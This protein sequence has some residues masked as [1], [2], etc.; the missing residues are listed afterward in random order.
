MTLSLRRVLRLSRWNVVLLS[1]N[2]L[3]LFYAV[4]LPLLP[5]ALL[6][7]GERGDESVGAGAATTVG[8]SSGSG[9]AT[10]ST[11][12]VS[13]SASASSSTNPSDS[14]R[15]VGAS[16]SGSPGRPRRMAP[17]TRSMQ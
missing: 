6:L 17:R 13:S 16:G 10:G 8:G 2:R 5:L 14:R 3:A 4:V 1:R 12:R 15:I 7:T 11:R 9:G